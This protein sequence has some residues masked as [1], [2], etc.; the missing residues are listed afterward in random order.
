MY[1]QYRPINITIYGTE[2]GNGFITWDG[3]FIPFTSTCSTK[4]SPK[5]NYYEYPYK[6]CIYELIADPTKRFKSCAFKN[7]TCPPPENMAWRYVGQSDPVP[8]C[9]DCRNP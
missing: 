5:P 8:D 2:V 6:C 1:S 4:Y 3:F 9:M 7:D